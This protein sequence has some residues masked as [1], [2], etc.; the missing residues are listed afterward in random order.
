MFEVASKFD[1]Y[2]DVVKEQGENTICI[3]NHGN[4]A[5]WVN[6]K[7]LAEANGMKYIHGM[8]AYVTDS[9][10]AKVADN[11]HLILLAT[12]LDGVYE[13]N[14]LSSQSFGGRGLDNGDN[15]FYFK[16]R[17][18]FEELKQTSDNILILTACLGG[19]LWQNR[20]DEQNFNKWL[21][22]FYE[23]RHR[24]YLEVQPHVD[25]NQKDYNKLLLALSEKYGFKLVAT[26][27][28]HAHSQEANMLRQIIKKGKGVEFESDDNFQLW[29]KNYD[30]MV[31]T[32]T[33][34]G[35]LSENQIHSALER[36]HEI[37]DRCTQYKVDTSVKFPQLYDNPKEKF[38]EEIKRGFVERG[39]SKLPI[40]EQKI[41]LS[42]I[43]YEYQTFIATD[44]INYMLLEWTVK[45]W[46]AEHD[47]YPGYGRGSVSGSL[48]AYL[49]HITEIDSIKYGLDFDRFM[50]KERVSLPD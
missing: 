42:R 40:E 47:I 20:L 10:D 3:T 35:V 16:P 46:A 41:Y 39:L 36:T 9:L 7:K 18:S 2:V 13:L 29:L 49:L 1:D 15:H 43:Q 27:D 25:D 8:E 38:Q 30:E 50:N 31:Q 32:F 11:Y 24:C 17:I 33:E 14:K 45:K 23:N 6:R 26:N 37:A 22:F 34:Q 4:I 12:N 28:V 19:P 5:G 21:K 48:I 44:S